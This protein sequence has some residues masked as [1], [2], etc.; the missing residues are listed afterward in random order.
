MIYWRAIGDLKIIFCQCMAH[1]YDQNSFW[2]KRNVRKKWKKTKM[3]VGGISAKNQ[4]V[5]NFKFRLFL[6]GG[7]DFSKFQMSEICPLF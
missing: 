5:H 1:I 7:T 3:G 6:D 4:E 2:K